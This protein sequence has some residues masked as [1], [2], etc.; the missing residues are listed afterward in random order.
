MSIHL[1]SVIIN[2]EDLYDIDLN[3]PIDKDKSCYDI[4]LSQISNFKI[5]SKNK[6]QSY[7]Y[8]RLKKKIKINETKVYKNW[9]T[10]L[11]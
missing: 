1:Y 10:E 9:I 8:K 2:E 11:V 3:E 5:N 7:K 4:Y 6:L